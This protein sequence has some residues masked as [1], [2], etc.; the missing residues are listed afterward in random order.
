MLKLRVKDIVE[1]QSVAHDLQAKVF[2]TGAIK[3]SS[4]AEQTQAFNTIFRM[5]AYVDLQN[6][7]KAQ[8]ADNPW[9]ESFFKGEQWVLNGNDPGA[10]EDAENWIHFTSTKMSAD[11]SVT[12]LALKKKM[13]ATFFCYILIA[14]LLGIWISMIYHRGKLKHS[15][16]PAPYKVPSAVGL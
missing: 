3:A 8:A 5:P 6:R 10:S 11:L 13:E 14:L 7:I 1:I 16:Q 15:M 12:T 4:V 9:G 2:N